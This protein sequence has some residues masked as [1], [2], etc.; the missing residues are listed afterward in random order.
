MQTHDHTSKTQDTKKTQACAAPLV[1]NPDRY[2][3]HLEGFDLTKEQ[4][5]EL[6]STLWDIMRTFVEIG[7]GLDS[8]QVVSLLMSESERD[9]KEECK[10]EDKDE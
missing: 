9:N 5:D 4:E 6:L 7:F 3:A 2:R 1:L 8:V 10:A